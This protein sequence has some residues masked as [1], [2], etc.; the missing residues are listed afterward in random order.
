MLS[1]ETLMEEFVVSRIRKPVVLIIIEFGYRDM[2]RLTTGFEF[3][4]SRDSDAGI[5]SDT[6]FVVFFTKSK[7]TVNWD[8]DQWN[9][10][11]NYRE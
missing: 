1:T 3:S 4:A 7:K 5:E 11:Y 8:V 9:Q 6:K 2:P 10:D